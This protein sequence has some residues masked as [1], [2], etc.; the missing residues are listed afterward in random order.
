MWAMT[1][2]EEHDSGIREK[3]FDEMTLASQFVALTAALWST[4]RSF[5]DCAGAVGDESTRSW[6]RLERVVVAGDTSLLSII[7]ICASSTV[8]VA[9][10]DWF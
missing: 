3:V 8:G 5:S 6:S 9:L 7:C 1:L 10:R 4:R 2:P